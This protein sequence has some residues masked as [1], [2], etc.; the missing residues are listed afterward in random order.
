MEPTTCV[1][2][3]KYS[4]QH[5]PFSYRLP[6]YVFV[7]LKENLLRLCR[8]PSLT[9]RVFVSKIQSRI[10][11][12]SLGRRPN[13]DRN[14]SPPLVSRFYT[15]SPGFYRSRDTRRRGPNP[16]HGGPGRIRQG[17]GYAVRKP[18]EW[19]LKERGDS[20]KGDTPGG[21]STDTRG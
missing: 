19:K 17:V 10:F 5:H 16:D 4:P 7:Q 2:R 18:S 14:V 20:Q 1:K 21:N 13:D 15:T 11:L 3:I 9:F 12:E 8:P 6:F